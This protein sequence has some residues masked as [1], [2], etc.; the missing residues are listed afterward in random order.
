MAPGQIEGQ[1]WRDA[2][3]L[4]RAVVAV[5]PLRLDPDRQ[6]SPKVSR[7]IAGNGSRVD[8]AAVAVKASISL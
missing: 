3:G 4:A 2:L 8:L 7:W 1:A 6:A 5:Q